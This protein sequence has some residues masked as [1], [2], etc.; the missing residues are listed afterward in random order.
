MD[1]REAFIALNMIER[2]G[3]VRVRQLL[4]YFT[5]APAILRA[6]RQQLLAVHGIGPDTADSIV[7]WE[8]NVDLAGELR[9]IQEFGCHVLIQDDENYPPSLK[10]I[11]DP[12]IVLYVKGTLD[13]KDRNSVAIVG[14]RQTT[15][16]GIEVARKFGYQLAYTGVTVVSGGARGIDTAAH[17]GALSAKGRTICV[18][19]TGIKLCSR[20]RTPN[21]SNA[22][23]RAAR[24]SRSTHSTARPTNNPSPSATASWPA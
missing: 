9:R 22:S 15:H 20:P 19:G 12:P 6:S 10:E 2:V 7:A 17:Q 24:S 23:A 5:E 1:S 21:C 4:E 13:A 16:Y 14:S 8:K 11:Y 3:P 18:L